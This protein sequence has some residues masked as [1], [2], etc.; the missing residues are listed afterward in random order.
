M[1]DQTHDTIKAGTVE[2]VAIQP[3]DRL[4]D[5]IRRMAARRCLCHGHSK[6]PGHGGP[7]CGVAG[8]RCVTCETR[9]LLNETTDDREDG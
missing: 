5:G 6:S 3:G 7:C 9:S 4:A 2:V 8:G 1:T